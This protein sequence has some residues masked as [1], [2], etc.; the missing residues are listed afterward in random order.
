MMID[1]RTYCCGET[2]RATEARRGETCEIAFAREDERTTLVGHRDARRT[3][4]SQSFFRRAS[5]ADS[6]A[7]SSNGSAVRREGILP[8]AAAAAHADNNNE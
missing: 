4:S 8:C 5:L 3:W 2:R 6:S 1:A 7:E